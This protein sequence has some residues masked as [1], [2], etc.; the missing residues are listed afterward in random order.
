MASLSD[1]L[2]HLADQG[3]VAALPAL[4]AYVAARAARVSDH[5]M[6]DETRRQKDLEEVPQNWEAMLAAQLMLTHTAICQ[7]AVDLWRTRMREVR[8]LVSC[9]AGRTAD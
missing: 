9:Y 3:L 4:E 8:S 2:G 6:S 7:G 5:S 1:Q